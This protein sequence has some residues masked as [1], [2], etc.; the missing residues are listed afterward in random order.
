MPVVYLT[1]RGLKAAVLG[2]RLEITPP[3]DPEGPCPE[4]RWIPLIDIEHV[5]L[6][7]GAYIS[8]Y[9]ITRLLTHQIPVLFIANKRFPGG[10]ASPLTR[11]TR[12][13]A[14]QLDACRDPDFRLRFSRSL[15][16]AKIRNMRRVLQRLGANRQQPALAAS[17]LQAMA[18]QAAAAQGLDSLRGIEGAATGRYFEC[19]A[20]FFPPD[21]PFERRSR[22]PPLNAANALLS[23]CYTLLTAEIALHLRSAGLEP[24]WGCFH[25]AEDGRPALALDWIEPF[26]APVV[27]ALALDLLNH[28]RLKA[29]D[30]EPGESGGI[31]LKRL[32]RRTVFSAW[33]DRLEREFHYQPD[34]ERTSLRGL[35]KKQ[36]RHLREAF[37][38][39]T[40]IPPFKMH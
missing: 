8:S 35:I 24:G 19:L 11:S 9:S 31:L 16:E 33:E 32:S 40:I 17:W 22:R 13:L 5:V 3:K 36:A 10:W 2:E 38:D 14:D 12:A 21:L 18:N 1:L 29:D 26:R 23:F 7:S 39:R 4:R 30:F 34:G 6:D 37:R 27:D 25:E 20:L 15:V 28:R